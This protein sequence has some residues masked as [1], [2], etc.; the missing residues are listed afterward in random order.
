[1][2]LTQKRT[3][4]EW[5]SALSGTLG[6]TE[7]TAAIQDLAD[8]LFRIAKRYLHNRR[9]TLLKLQFY[10]E[11]EITGM[12][13]EMVQC[14]MEKLVKDGFDLLKKYSGKGS[15][16][17]WAAQVI[18]NLCRSELR[19]K[20]WRTTKP[21]DCIGPVVDHQSNQ[22]DMIVIRAQLREQI[23]FCLDQLPGRYRIAL[24]G[25]IVEGRSATE[26]GKILGVSAN[27]VNILVYRGKKRLRDKFDDVGI[28]SGTLTAFA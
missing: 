9:N 23:I 28:G 8:F 6:Q 3:N 16:N 7:Q 2:R 19:R 22:P 10:T 24:V 4:E 1:M 27:A 15:F 17:G 18:V 14:F 13:E 11:Q 12:A 20:A 21:L 5:L 25:I 26:V